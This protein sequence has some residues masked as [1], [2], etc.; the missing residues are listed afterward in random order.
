MKLLI[1]SHFFAPSVGGVE[2]IVRSLAIGLANLR[3]EQ[4]A[5]Q[6]DI[7]LIT[8][9]PSNGSDD[10]SLPFRLVRQPGTIELF[11][12]ISNSE[13]IHIAGPALVPMAI[14]LLL[15]K[16]I[17]VEHHGFHPICPNGQLLF[18]PTQRLCSG[19]FMAGNHR[20]CLRCNASTGFVISCKLWLLTFVRR[21]FCTLVSRNVVP[22][23][24]LGE[25]LRLPQTVTIPHGVEPLKAFSRDQETVG[26]PLIGFQG[27]LVTT[28]GVQIL[29]EAS[30]IL[31]QQNCPFE[32]VIIGDGPERKTL[33]QLAGELGLAEYVRFTGR[34][35]DSEVEATIASAS[36]IVVPS[37]A[38]EVFG[39][40]VAENMQRGL[41]VVA[42]DLGAFREVLGD[43]G[44]T[45]HT[46]DSSDLASKLFELLN[47]PSLRSSLAQRARNRSEALFS[48]KRMIELHA[49]LYKR[50]DRRKARTSAASSRQLH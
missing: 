48:Q 24:W 44:M 37:L 16:P 12:L 36:V 10:Q 40:V 8:E 11:R 33:E 18:E 13:V 45:F 49:D 23:M 15:G 7:T 31:R 2:T 9:I 28:K 32:I 38:G 25:L 39:L 3:S 17:V 50:L 34:L 27:R 47:N 43:A 14:G 4:E 19:H 41:P 35:P 26:D 21:L 20:E 5:P 29:I 30:R 42:S 6:F 22:T 1:Y 46:G